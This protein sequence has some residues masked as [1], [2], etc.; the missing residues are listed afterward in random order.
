MS[1][2][3]TTLRVA[4][5]VESLESGGAEALAVDI[6]G[7]LADRGHESHLVVLRGGGPFRSR[8]SS[9]VIFHDLERPRRDGSQLER[10]QYFLETGRRLGSLMRSQRID[11]LQTHLPKAN[12]LGLMT[13]WRS[14]C[15]VCP[16]VHNNREFDYGDNAGPLKQRLRRT[17]YR[18]M[19]ERCH[20]VIA[21]SEQVRRSLIDELGLASAEAARIK[22]VTN[23]VRVP[24][25]PSAA[26][27][28]GARAAWQVGEGELLV[29]AVGRLTRQKNF[30]I[31]VEALAALPEESPHWKCVVAGEGELRGDLERQV[32][33]NGLEGRTKLAGL[34]PDVSTLLAAADVFCLPSLYEGLPLVLL[35]AMAAGLPVAAFAIDG[36]TDVVTN[37]VEA[38]LAAP[39]S[40]AGLGSALAGLLSDAEERRRLGTAGRELVVRRYEFGSVVDRLE[41]VYSA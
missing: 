11:V 32:V 34:V 8:V 4:Q 26:E 25:V 2:P 29:A 10:I 40:A 13:G 33:A 35:E 22:V 27:R 36:V 14:V 16:T 28:A 21:V 31:L 7:A 9:A 6:A 5:L 37:G 15:R 1:G 23:G 41:T 38:R 17:A 30:G 12:F 39:G 24:A 3:K 19:L 20:A 18:Q